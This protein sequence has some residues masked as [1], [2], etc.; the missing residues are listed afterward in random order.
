MV[1]LYLK[2]FLKNPDDF[3]G[4]VAEQRDI[5]ATRVRV[6]EIIQAKVDQR[7]IIDSASKLTSSVNSNISR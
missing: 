3:L 6:G 4:K 7:E 1:S 2:A 5:L